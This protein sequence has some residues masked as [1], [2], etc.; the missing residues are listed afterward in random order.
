LGKATAVLTALL[1]LQITLAISSKYSVFPL[2]DAFTHTR[3]EDGERGP[4]LLFLF[5]LMLCLPTLALLLSAFVIRAILSWRRPRSIPTIVPPRDD[6][7][8]HYGL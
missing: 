6:P 3:I 5:Q 1:L 7:D 2:Y 8:N 4:F